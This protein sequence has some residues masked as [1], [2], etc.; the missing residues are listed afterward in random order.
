MNYSEAYE[1]ITKILKKDREEMRDR[2]IKALNEL[3]KKLWNSP[4]TDD[5]TKSYGVRDAIKMVEKE[6]V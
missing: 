1:T 5:Q 6:F 2:I 3:D 4:K